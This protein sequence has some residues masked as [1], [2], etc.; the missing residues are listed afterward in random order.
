[1]L[2]TVLVVDDYSYVLEVLARSLA[3]AGFQVLS[4]SSA[5]QALE[6]VSDPDCRIDLLICDVILPGMPG[7]QLVRRV[8]ELRPD[9]RCLFITG[10][11]D[12][13][14]ATHELSTGHAMLPKPFM[15]DLLIRRA[16]EV[17]GVCTQTIAATA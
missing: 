6:I 7:P 14:L 4:A 9:I 13:P 1:M 2:Q 11:P 15:P 17:L 5:E 16:R 8:L 3:Y 12:H 10:L